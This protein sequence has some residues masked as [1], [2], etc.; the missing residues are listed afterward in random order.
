MRTGAGPANL[1]GRVRSE[2][3]RYVGVTPFAKPVT[4]RYHKAVF[5]LRMTRDGGSIHAV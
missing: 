1:V 3:T 5:G 4:F 2:L